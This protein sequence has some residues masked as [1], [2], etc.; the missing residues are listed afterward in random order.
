MRQFNPLLMENLNI[1][2]IEEIIVFTI[3]LIIILSPC[4][5]IF[6]PIYQKGLTYLH[7]YGHI[8]HLRISATI[9]KQKYSKSTLKVD[10]EKLQFSGFT[11]NS[12]YYYFQ[13]NKLYGFIRVQAL[14]GAGLVVICTIIFF[15]LSFLLKQY[16]FG[17]QI[18][19][20]LTIVMELFT[21]FHGGDFQ[22]FLHPERFDYEKQ[23]KK[24]NLL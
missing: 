18:L 21:F 4:L 10:G 23:L 20:V 16:V 8:A 22:Y 11:K 17:F 2:E 6:L 19:F 1:Q 24:H 15:S 12:L 5:L 14:S 3:F 9:L 7:E 13:Y